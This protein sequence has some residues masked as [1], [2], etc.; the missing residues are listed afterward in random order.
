MK[1]EERFTINAPADAVWAFLIDPER[2]AAALPGAEIIE[3]VDDTT[4]KG[5]MA[6]RVGPISANYRGTL[7]F[8]LDEPAKTAVVV[9]KGQ[10]MAGMGSA[11]MQMT[12]KVRSL[13]DTETEVTVDADVTISG[14]LAQFGRGMIEQVS[15]KMFQEF[16]AA[17][18]LELETG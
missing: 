11:H 4:F 1:I 14:V 15:K 13:G 3:K 2:V 5:G 10:G 8:E 18:K 12:S 17:M 6:V 7:S 16:T 9:A